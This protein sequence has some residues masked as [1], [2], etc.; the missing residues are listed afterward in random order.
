VSDR[1]ETQAFLSGF[2]AEV[3]ELLGNAGARLL[4]LEESE[5]R[6]EPNPRAVRE[7]Y[8]L[9]HTV[10]GLSAMMEVAPVVG[11]AHAME[12]L[13]RAADRAAGRLPPG[14]P[15]R[16]LAGLRAIEERIA[17]LA[18][19][20]AVPPA[21]VELI[22]ALEALPA[23]A[24]PPPGPGPLA[25][26]ADLETRLTP[27]ERE[28]LARGVARGRTAVRLD[29]V[30]SKE[31]AARGLDITRV[32]E[33][34]GS[35]G[36]IVRVLPLSVPAGEGAPGGLAFAL[37][38]LADVPPADVARAAS[39]PAEAA[40]ALAGAE[41]PPPA[42][43]AAPPAPPPPAAPVG[44]AG[45]PAG[46]EGLDEVRGPG[47]RS[48]VRI[49]VARLDDALEKLSALVVGRFHLARVVGTLAATGADVRE[50]Q[51]V[52]AEQ[53]RQLRRLRG[54]ILLARMVP[55]SLALQRLPLL[56]RGLARATGKRVRL[57][58]EAGDAELDKSVADRISPAIVHLVRN[59]VDHAIEPP[60]ERRRQGKPE[61]GRIRVT[62]VQ[63]SSNQLDL[64]I[65]DDGRGIDRA[66][67]ARRA[68]VEPPAGNAALLEL[69][70]RAGLSTL[71][72]ATAT[73]GR[74]MGMDIVR[75]AVVDE[76]GGEL[77]LE[78]SPRG[79][80]FLLRIPLTITIVDALAFLAAGQR[81]VA[82]VTGVEEI[83]EVDP[84]AVRDVPGGPSGGGLR[85]LAR[86]GEVV[87][88]APLGRALGIGTDGRA[89]TKALVVR[90]HGK[91][92]AFQVERMLGQ[93][94][95]VVRPVLDP[96]VR[97]PGVSGT[98]DLGDGRPTLVLDL[99]ALTGHLA[100][101][102]RAGGPA[103]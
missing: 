81:F 97:T 101:G 50:L 98:T 82:P 22:E 76:L 44:E 49:D 39:L 4:A 69:I 18:A 83:V 42:P 86:R 48:F 6:G 70:T 37:F 2:L 14:A 36:E 24:P 93:Q 47:G 78:T 30:P 91:P 7:L 65:A 61:E 28:E 25:L 95:V 26:P 94:E 92:F 20:R 99:P 10:K 90:R 38:V 60:E 68:G 40:V 8:R 33:A 89:A 13:L 51:A 52:V 3:G 87:P 9:L 75:R 11:L 64:E 17:E 72:R 88:L 45:V 74:G 96:L 79:T 29:F 21:P 102:A 55:V 27:S 46:P 35:V 100:A 53:G 5:S 1:L 58:M 66:E 73:S 71:D 62:C 19:G 15:D 84:A 67:V 12:N 57:E 32:R 54:S 103:A 41:R 23:P 63:R 85:L 34:V 56:V 31:R 43:E 80:A 16:L 59:A 77:R